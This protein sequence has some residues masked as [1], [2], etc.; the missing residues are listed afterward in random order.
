MIPTRRIGAT[1][2]S[3]DTW[4]LPLLV[5]KTPSLVPSEGVAVLFKSTPKMWPPLTLIKWCRP[6]CS[7]VPHSLKPND[8]PQTG[9]A[10][11]IHNFPEGLATFV[12][13]LS[14]PRL[15][16][17]LAVAIAIHNVPEGVCVALPVYY[18]TGSKWKGFLW[19]FLSGISEP[20]GENQTN[21]S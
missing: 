18:A 21:D 1:F 9:L 17:A 10:I 4:R 13:T 7:A 12:A 19:A 20:I 11:G 15:G 14:H 16:A 2:E 8:L 6:L 5:V 3:F